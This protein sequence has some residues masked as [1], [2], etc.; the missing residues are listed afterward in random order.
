MNKS[1]LVVSIIKKTGLSKKDVEKA[2]NAFIE[3][4]SEALKKDEKVQLVGFGTFEV[5]NRA[6]REGMNPSTGEKIQIA[7]KKVP[8]FKA[9]KSLKDSLK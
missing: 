7:A 5:R 4:I 3:S 8:V 9:G 1:E 6:A 2:T